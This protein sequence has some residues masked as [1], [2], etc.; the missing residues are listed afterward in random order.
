MIRKVVTI[1]S[2]VFIGYSSYAVHLVRDTLPSGILSD[3]NFIEICDN[4]IDDDN[5]GFLDSYDSDCPC[6]D[7]LFNNSCFNDC[8]SILIDTSFQLAKKWASDI[9]GTS[10]GNIL[11]FDS[12]IFTKKIEGG[13]SYFAPE[14]RNSY[15]KLN[16]KSG[17][18]LNQNPYSSWSSWPSDYT[19]LAIFS[20]RDTI[21]TVIL[22][23]DTLM[24]FDYN[25]SKKWESY[26][27]SSFP[28][29]SHPA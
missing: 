10:I 6:Q 5:D 15:V 2:L 18:V 24:M 8:Q 4:G 25:N 12:L 23:R 28:S 26:G 21:F 22:H 9:I 7:T 20:W 3:L 19:P 17:I 1:L 13:Y 16:G 14:S 11:V 29:L 27:F